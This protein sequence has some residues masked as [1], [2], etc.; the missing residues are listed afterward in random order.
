MTVEQL[1]ERM[2]KWLQGE[3]R[4]VLFSTSEPVAYALYRQE[5]DLIYLRQFFVRRDSRGAGIGHSAFS[6]LRQQIWPPGIRLTVEVLCRN[7]GG[8]AFWRRV[9]YQD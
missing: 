1:A 8:V 3:Y 4:A 6:I 7:Q 9:C 5:A 2:R